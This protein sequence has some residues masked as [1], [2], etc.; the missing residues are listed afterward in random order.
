MRLALYEHLHIMT[1]ADHPPNDVQTDLTVSLEKARDDGRHASAALNDLRVSS[2]S[3][4]ADLKRDI[5]SKSAELT[6]LKS[7]EQR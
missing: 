5:A 7:D 6:R 4:I 1:H 3:L 2:D